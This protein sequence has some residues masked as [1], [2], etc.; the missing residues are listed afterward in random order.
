M[1]NNV[2][3]YYETIEEDSR[4]SRNSRKIEFLTTIHTL[5]KRM[6]PHAKILDVGSGTGVYA[7][8]YAQQH[9]EVV[10]IDITPKHIDILKDKAKRQGLPIEAH[11]AN[12]TDL[13]EYTSDAFDFVLCFG[14]MY[15]LTDPSDRNRCIQECLSVLKQGGHLAIAYINKYSIMPMLA[16]RDNTF[17]RGSVIDKVLDEGVIFEGDEDCFWTDAYFTSPDEI[18]AFMQQYPV[19]VTEHVGTDGIS[20]TIQHDVD[21]LDEAQFEAWMDYHLRTC[22]ER[23]IL[24]LSSHGL[25]VC[26][27]N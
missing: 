9:H 17:I 16:T 22:S 15:H 23:S 20:H 19:T 25:F 13:S 7:L 24:G 18:E 12:A 3:Q 6:P 2:V 10:A 11:V 26:E 8:H 5:S 21:R 4:F 27:K 14:P 1:M